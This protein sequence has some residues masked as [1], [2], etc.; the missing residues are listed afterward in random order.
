M[1]RRKGRPSPP[2]SSVSK[3]PV[4]FEIPA[5]L[6]HF[7]T[8]SRSL[9]ATMATGTGTSYHPSSKSTSTPQVSTK[10]TPA[11]T[12]SQ[13]RPNSQSALHSPS[14]F[15][16]TPR[17]GQYP[18]NKANPLKRSFSESQ[19]DSR[20][21]HRPPSSK[22]TSRAT[23]QSNTLPQAL[24]EATGAVA[25]S[26]SLSLQTP[27]LHISTSTPA[28]EPPLRPGEK[29]VL[30]THPNLIAQLIARKRAENEKLGIRER[31]ARKQQEYRM[32]QSSATQSAN[33]LSPQVDHRKIP[34][35]SPESSSTPPLARSPSAIP[36]LEPATSNMLDAQTPAAES[37]STSATEDSIKPAENTSEPRPSKDN[38]SF[39]ESPFSSPIVEFLEKATENA[40]LKEPLKHDGAM[41]TNTV[42]T[43]AASPVSHPESAAKPSS[44]TLTTNKFQEASAIPPLFSDKPLTNQSQSQPFRKNSTQSPSVNMHQQPQ[45]DSLAPGQAQVSQQ[46][47]RGGPP[48]LAPRQL[49]APRPIP[50]YPQ[51]AGMPGFYRVEMTQSWP[52]RSS[53]FAATPVSAVSSTH[54]YEQQILS[55]SMAYS[56]YGVGSMASYVVGPELPPPPGP[57]HTYG[58]TMAPAATGQRREHLLNTGHITAAD[59]VAGINT[60]F[61]IATKDD[62]A[63]PKR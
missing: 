40:G 25:V 58:S 1:T 18:T 37:P 12:L 9:A 16:T 13:P 21:D 15:S 36:T 53:N 27:H 61:K 5:S 62:F 30:A 56:P 32:L 35:A 29:L 6:H 57:L 41:S 39:F 38:D 51:N 28:E 34:Q 42:S 11:K 17:A 14:S 43:V 19:H 45:T 55:P 47:Q 2:P 63:V 3:S 49:P 24:A 44:S 46:Q 48:H 54:T 59:I 10:P 33:E 60:K 50:F 52:G 20:S 26:S 8:L 22:A 4:S 7:S 23:K 31:W